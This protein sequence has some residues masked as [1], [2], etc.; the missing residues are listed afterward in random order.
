MTEVTVAK[1]EKNHEVDM[2]LEIKFVHAVLRSQTVIYG[3]GFE[4]LEFHY[5]IIYRL[6][7]K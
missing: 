6:P 4:R 5:L 2:R 7:T 3:A 1:T